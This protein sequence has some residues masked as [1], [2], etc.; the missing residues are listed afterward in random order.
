MG[1][2][3][4]PW[5]DLMAPWPRREP[6]PERTGRAMPWHMAGAEIRLLVVAQNPDFPG[7]GYYHSSPTFGGGWF[8]KGYNSW[9]IY[10]MAEPA[11]TE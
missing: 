7:R 11:K 9:L 4:L 6:D 3:R 8:H 2:F 5:P 1:E 10:K